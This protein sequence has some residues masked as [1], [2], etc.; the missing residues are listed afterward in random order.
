MTERKL[1]HLVIIAAV[2]LMP[3]VAAAQRP[4]TGGEGRGGP[5]GRQMGKPA[6]EVQEKVRK[7]VREVAPEVRKEI[8]EIEG[9][10]ERA[11]GEL[12]EALSAKAVNEQEVMK[13][14][15]RI[16]ELETALRKAR[17]RAEIAVAK[18]LGP[19]RR[20]LLGRFL[21]ERA[22]ER[23][24][25]APGRGVNPP[26]IGQRLMMGRRLR[27]MAGGRQMMGFGRMCPWC[28]RPCPGLGLG[29]QGMGAGPRGM[30]MGPGRM[31]GMGTGP[32]PEALG[33][34]G[35]EGR[36]G[37]PGMGRG[38]GLG[39]GMGPGRMRGMG[40]G[41]MPEALG[42]QGPEGRP[43]APMGP[44]MGR[45]GMGPRSERLGPAEPPSS[46]RRDRPEGRPEREGERPKV[47]QKIEKPRPDVKPPKEKPEERREER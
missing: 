18:E 41:S 24:G 15:D 43:G 20:P 6:P 22:A 2:V 28:G 26:G 25:F 44:A 47:E 37:R 36:P 30:G 33:P 39:M 45:P 5:W 1:Q 19:E 12:R 7:A 17:L 40:T 34:R 35:P 27:G 8:A 31:R 42:P 29:R 21:G 9:N 13:I 23:P 3:L 4:R 38:P 11:N 10:L 46:S 32:M 16:G 14:A